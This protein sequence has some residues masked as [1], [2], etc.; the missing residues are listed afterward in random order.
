MSDIQKQLEDVIAVNDG[1]GDLNE[2][3]VRYRRQGSG[4]SSVGGALEARIAKLES[5]VDHMRGDIGELKVDVRE[6]RTEMRDVRERLARLE[7]KVAHLPGKGFI[8]GSVLLSLAVIGGLITFQG[9]IQNLV[10]AQPAAVAT[11]R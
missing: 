3:V 7:E 6:F 8:V 5:D 9:P 10:G 1:A 2:A 11:A 4:G